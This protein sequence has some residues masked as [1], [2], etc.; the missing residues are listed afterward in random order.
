[1]YRLLFDELTNVIVKP[2]AAASLFL[3]HTAIIQSA[4]QIQ[5]NFT[6]I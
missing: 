3:K 1:M 2:S 4:I 6:D 5:Y